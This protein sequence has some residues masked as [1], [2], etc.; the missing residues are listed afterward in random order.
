MAW[1]SSF[2]SSQRPSNRRPRSEAHVVGPQ[3][4]DGEDAQ[5]RL[6]ANTASSALSSNSP[7][8]T[9]PQA[10]GLEPVVQCRAQ[11]RVAGGQQHRQAVQRLRKG[12][13]R[14]IL[15]HQGWPGRTTRSAIRPAARW[16][17]A[18]S[19]CAA[20]PARPAP[21]PGGAAPV[22]PAAVRPRLRGRPGAAAAWPAPAPAARGRPAWRC[23]PKG[24]PPSRDHRAAGG[25]AH[26]VGDALAE[27][28]D[29]LR[30][31]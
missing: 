1:I 10:L 9:R 7:A 12:G 24:R 26:F 14:S 13:S 17:G 25:R 5:S 11:G 16:S 18:G 27:L 6:A 22:R 8:M 23:R 28:E 3:P 31:A 19:D 4:A 29:L 15:A 2:T 30:R 20:P 21:G